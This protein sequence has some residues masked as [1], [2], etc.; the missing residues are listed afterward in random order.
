[1]QDGQDGLWAACPPCSLPTLPGA[2]SSQGLQP[3]L[4]SQTSVSALSHSHPCTRTC[5]HAR[6]YYT[7]IHT[8]Q[9]PVIS[10]ILMERKTGSWK[11]PNLSPQVCPFSVPHPWRGWRCPGWDRT[12]LGPLC[13]MA[14]TQILPASGVHPLVC[15]HAQRT[16]PLAVKPHQ[17]AGDLWVTIHCPSHPQ[18]WAHCCSMKFLPLNQ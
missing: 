9:A 2:V 11:F 13:L 5:T 14:L 4:G 15:V 10:N 12:E 7:C 16:C 8:P 1:M 17:S 18:H 3:E 6:L